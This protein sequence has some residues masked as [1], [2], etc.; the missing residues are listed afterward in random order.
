MTVSPERYRQIAIASLVAIFVVIVA[1]AAVR[2]TNSGL[3]C[4]DWPNCNETTFVDVSSD[5]TAGGLKWSVSTTA[6]GAKLGGQPVALPPRQKGSG[7]RFKFGVAAPYVATETDGSQ[8][9]PST[10]TSP[11]GNENLE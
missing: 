11:P 9:R 8:I 7:P 1:G 2:L 10:G 4:D 6:T 5:G 3:G